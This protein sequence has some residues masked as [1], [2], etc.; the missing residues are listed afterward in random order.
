M[1][2]KASTGDNEML[3]DLQ[4]A[5]EDT[6]SALNDLAEE[7]GN[8]SKGM[9]D[10]I[11]ANLQDLKQKLLETEKMVAEKAKVAAKATDEYVHENPWQSI[12]VAAGIGFLVGLLV[13]RR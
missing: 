13:S 3:S 9:R 8:L 6:E 7:G 4:A 1:A 12:G 5:L 11:S 2:T 10:K